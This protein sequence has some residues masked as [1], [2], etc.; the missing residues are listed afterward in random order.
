MIWALK[1]EKVLNIN[2]GRG[3]AMDKFSNFNPK[4]CFL[5]FV[6]IIQSHVKPHSVNICIPADLSCSLVIDYPQSSRCTVLFGK[7]YQQ[8]KCQY[9]RQDHHQ[10]LI[11]A[12]HL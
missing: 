12:G 7:E 2:F 9:I 5:F 1:Q 4:V 3:S 6:V 8:Q 10:I 11:T